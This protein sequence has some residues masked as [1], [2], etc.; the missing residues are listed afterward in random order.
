MSMEVKVTVTRIYVV[1]QAMDR[2][3]MKFGIFQQPREN[4]GLHV[5]RKCF[6]CGHKFTD[7]EDTFLVLFKN[8]HNRLFCRECNEN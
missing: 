8:T 5:E 7:D 6:N 2:P 1:S 4:L 3:F